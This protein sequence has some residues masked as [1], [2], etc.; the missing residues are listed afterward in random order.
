M[1]GTITT[2]N[3]MRVYTPAAAP[4]EW[5]PRVV[6]PDGQIKTFKD[7]SI[8]GRMVSKVYDEAWGIKDGKLVLIGR[9]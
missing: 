8:I 1:P 3:H 6:R 4:S 7:L 2:G 5:S 9:R